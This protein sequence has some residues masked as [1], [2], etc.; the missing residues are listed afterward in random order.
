ME[1]LTLSRQCA[2]LEKQRIGEED[3]DTDAVISDQVFK[4]EIQNMMRK[5]SGLTSGFILWL[6]FTRK[7]LTGND[8]LLQRP[9][10]LPKLDNI[11]AL[12]DVDNDEDEEVNPRAPVSA[13][14]ALHARKIASVARKQLTSVD[15]KTI[16]V[17]DINDRRS[18]QGQ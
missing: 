2:R 8:F 11:R 6:D 12:A 1:I 10:M 5:S 9:V 13:K 15:K 16:E 4:D 14:L 7:S 18:I 17:A 3:L